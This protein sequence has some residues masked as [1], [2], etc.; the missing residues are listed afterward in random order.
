MGAPHLHEIYK[1]TMCL[2]EEMP[3]EEKKILTH[4]SRL[5]EFLVGS[6]GK[7]EP[8]AIGGAWSPSLDGENPR[9]NPRVLIRTAVRTCKALTGIDL[10]SCLRW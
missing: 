3:K 1:K 9:T 7:G 8:M 2:A 10:S 5:V 4:V 6:R